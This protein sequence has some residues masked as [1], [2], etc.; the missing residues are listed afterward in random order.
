[1]LVTELS[2]ARRIPDSE[3]ILIM[4]RALAKTGLMLPAVY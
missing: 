3:A 2:M 4:D 1:M